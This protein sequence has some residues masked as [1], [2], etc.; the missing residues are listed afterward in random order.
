MRDKVVTSDRTSSVS[1][2]HGSSHSKETA[3]PVEL[4]VGI[5]ATPM[6]PFLVTPVAPFESSSQRVAETAAAYY[7]ECFVE[8]S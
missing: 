6:A 8:V 4:Q 1:V 7:G 5:D 2:E 3:G